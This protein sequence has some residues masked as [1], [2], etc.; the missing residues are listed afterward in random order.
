MLSISLERYNNVHLDNN[1][2]WS[3][4]LKQ[5]IRWQKWPS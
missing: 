2:D 1:I 5:F 3:N 4:N